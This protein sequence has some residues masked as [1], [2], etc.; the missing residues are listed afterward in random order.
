[1][2]TTSG[3]SVVLTREGD[4]ARV[5]LNRPH[6]LNALNRDLVFELEDA[7]QQASTSGAI[8]LTGAGRAFCAGEDLMDGL[9]IEGD[10]GAGLREALMALQRVTQ[11]LVAFPGPVVAAVAGYAVGG[12]AEL[13]LAADFV[14]CAPGAQFRFPEVPLGYAHTGGVTQRLAAT[15]GLGRA[16]ELLLTGR[17]LGA[18]E[19][20]L[21]GLVAEVVVDAENRAI[22][23]AGEIARYPRRSVEAAKRSVELAGG[24][25][26]DA[27]LYREV[28][29][30]MW[31]FASTEAEASFER[32]RRHTG[33][34]PVSDV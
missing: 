23:L 16:K 31:C 18:D 6:R 29:A 20:K 26:L 8:V 11:A 13:A 27:A 25:A 28:D 17:W 19:A 10:G 15:V 34:Q 3:R 30:A 33:S 7:V 2:S 1:M 5:M 22:E 4:T 12:G 24:S 32:F 14:I 21:I 9:G